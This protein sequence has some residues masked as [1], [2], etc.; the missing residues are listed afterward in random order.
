MPI[1]DEQYRVIGVEA[2]RLKIRGERSGNVLV[3][4]ADPEAPLSQKD[5]P[6]G[7]LIVLSDPSTARPN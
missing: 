1:F 5:F 6:L 7:K 2:H 3:I 4:N